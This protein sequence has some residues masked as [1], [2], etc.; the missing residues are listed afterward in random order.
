MI[1]YLLFQL[2]NTESVPCVS[3]IHLKIKRC[4][5]LVANGGAIL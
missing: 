5:T 3:E 2:S 1:G 4:L